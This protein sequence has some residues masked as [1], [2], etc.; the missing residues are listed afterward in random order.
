MRK[1]VEYLEGAT[2]SRR[3]AEFEFRPGDLV[4]SVPSKCGT[5]WLQMVCA[6]LIFGPQM[7]GSLTNLSPWLD[8]RLQPL[9]EVRDRLAAQQHRRFIKTHT[10]LD[11][12]PQ[13]SDVSYLVMG[14]DPRDAGIS[15]V[16]HRANLN[17]EL[18]SERLA[19]ATGGG[20]RQQTASAPID[21]HDQVMLWIEDV[22]PVESALS[23]LK[24]MTWHL[25]QA[26]ERR[27][28]DNIVLLHY[29]EFSGDLEGQ[30][31]RL[32]SR[33]GVEIESGE[34]PELVAR[35]QIGSMRADAASFVP[36]E[37][38]G[39]FKDADQFFR[40]G[41]SGQWT[42]IL[43]VS[44]LHRYDARMAELAEPEVITWL[45]QTAV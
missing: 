7:P 34:W 37:G 20:S 18:I 35:A 40:N 23:S 29:A 44:D 31:R 27:D 30:M 13:R 1:P 15:M 4:I 41:R 6:L 24:G 2:D 8:M 42:D 14:R 36:D 21:A 25:G 43:D 33:L 5:T 16:H 22:R 26:Y 12:L 3:W 19:Q 11:G 17:S 10:P 32:A 39:L 45:H 9:D 28:E 38:I